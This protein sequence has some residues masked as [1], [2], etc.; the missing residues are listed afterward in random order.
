MTRSM[1]RRLI[2]EEEGQSLTE[3]GLIIGLIAVA[4]I[5]ALQ[6]LGGNINT[7]FNSIGTKLGTISP[8]K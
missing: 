2:Q 8:V 6:A 1:I 3:Y 4:A 7:F 5:V